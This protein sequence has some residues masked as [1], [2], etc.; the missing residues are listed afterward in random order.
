MLIF[1]F[2]I[3]SFFYNLEFFVKA[4]DETIDSDIAIFFQKFNI[5]L[6]VSDYRGY[7][8]SGGNPTKQ[9]LHSDS[10]QILD[11]VKKYLLQNWEM[12]IG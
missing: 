10:L 6:I 4:S 1:F 11:Y 8:L 5:N 3:F 9:N 12:L 7:G 2:F